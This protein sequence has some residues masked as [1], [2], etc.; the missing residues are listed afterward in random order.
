MRGTF[1]DLIPFLRGDRPLDSCWRSDHEAL[2]R[3]VGAGRHERT[4]THEA[5][6]ADAGAVEDHRAHADQTEV[7]DRAGVNDR[8][9]PDGAIAADRSAE[10]AARH[11]DDRVVLDRCAWA[12]PDRQLS[13]CLMTSGKPLI[14]L[15]QLVWLNI[16]RTIARLCPP[17]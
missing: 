6:A 9:V 15:D 10:P 3:D 13:A 7:L 5:A 11:V 1:C 16:P 4:C 2:G 8:A 14:T 17:R 12:D